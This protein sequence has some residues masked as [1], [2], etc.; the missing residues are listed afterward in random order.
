MKRHCV[1]ACF[2]EGCYAFKPS[3]LSPNFI[4]ATHYDFTPSASDGVRR[5]RRIRRTLARKLGAG[6]LAA[7]P[8]ELC[9][10]VAEHLVR[11]CA[12]TTCQELTSYS[13]GR[14]SDVDL[15]SDVYATYVNVEGIHY[16]QSLDNQSGPRGDERVEL[17]FDAKRQGDVQNV[18]V[19]YDHLGVRDVF[20][21]TH[22]KHRSPHLSPVTRG[23][24]WRGLGKGSRPLR[25]TTKSDV[26]I[27]E[28][29]CA[30]QPNMNTL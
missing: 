7:M 13:H 3:P 30:E 29:F 18:Y 16:V 22:P 15:S 6:V 4:P 17:I 12:V 24:W 2:H 27:L 9:L 23:V 25:L 1:A 10:M 14:D 26:C 20:F 21:E 11:E 19:A 5:R 8:E 28:V